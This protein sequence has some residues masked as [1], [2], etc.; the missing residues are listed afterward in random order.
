M[1]LA[2]GQLQ[3][4]VDGQLREHADRAIEVLP[5]LPRILVGAAE[6]QLDAADLQPLAALAQHRARVRPQAQRVL[7]LAL[8]PGEVAAHALGHRPLEPVVGALGQPHGALAGAIR[9][10]EASQ[11]RQR[12][13]A[14]ALDL[15]DHIA[16]VG[17]YNIDPRSENLNNE[18]MCMADDPETARALLDAIDVHVRNSWQ[19]D[20]DGRARE[21]FPGARSRSFRAWMVRLLL[22][23]IQ[24]QL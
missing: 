13:G 16:L 5:G 18:L 8:R 1:E 23:V 7:A 3:P 17:S 9:L 15:D 20:V 10:V 24:G 12:L 2:L 11:G 22:P 6:R 4:V 21:D 19:V 14:T